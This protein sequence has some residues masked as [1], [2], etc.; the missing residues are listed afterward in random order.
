MGEIR[1]PSFEVVIGFKGVGKTY[2]TNEVI[3]DYIKTAPGGRKGRPVLV[4]DINNEYCDSNGYT[5]YKAIDFDVTEKNEFK[6]AEQIRNIKAPAK[7]RILPYKKDRTPMTISELVTTASTIVKYYRNGLLVLEDINKYTLSSYKQ[8]F[9]GM[10]IGLRH[11]GVDLVAHFQT[12][13]AIPPKVWGNMNYLRWHKQSDRIFKYKGRID[14]FELFSIAEC[15][16]DYKYQSDQRYYLWIS[17]LEEKLI[18]VTPEDFKQGCIHYLS[19]HPQEL[20]K[21]MNHISNDGNKKYKTSHEAITGFADEK[22][23][24]YLSQ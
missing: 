14:N 10:F 20:S 12:L 22:A 23:K 13:R 16:V 2:T 11:L 17:V 21:I 19:T 7:Y 18:N 9:V 6:R 4:F 1:E 24:Q 15:I 8:E 3:N 5:G